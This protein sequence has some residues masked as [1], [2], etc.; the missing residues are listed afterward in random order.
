MQPTYATPGSSAKWYTLV[1]FDAGIAAGFLETL[2]SKDTGFLEVSLVV[3][4]RNQAHDDSCALGHLGAICKGK[5]RIILGTTYTQFM[6][7]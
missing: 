1:G 7:H 3:A 5:L 6:T 2:R 4:H